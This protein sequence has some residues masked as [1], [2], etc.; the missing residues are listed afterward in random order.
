MSKHF[1]TSMFGS[2]FIAIEFIEVLRYKLRMFGIPIEGPTNCYIDTDTV[3]S[4]SS[5]P[6]F[7]LKK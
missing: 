7:T 6:E 3:V 5:Q 4:S 2:K 1:E